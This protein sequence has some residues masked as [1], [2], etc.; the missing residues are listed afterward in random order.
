MGANPGKSFRRAKTIRSI[1]R[2]VPRGSQE[3]WRT[4]HTC[5]FTM[6]PS[7]FCD[8]VPAISCNWFAPSGPWAGAGGPP[9]EAPTFGNVS[10]VWPDSTA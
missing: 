6:G 9:V 10:C 4:C 5:G 2:R 1:F 3:K 7:W 8:A